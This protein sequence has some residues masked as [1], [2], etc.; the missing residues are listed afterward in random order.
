ML[1]PFVHTLRLLPTLDRQDKLVDPYPADYCYPTEVIDLPLP[2]KTCLDLPAHTAAKR[3]RSLTSLL[4]QRNPHLLADTLRFSKELMKGQ[5]HLPQDSE[6]RAPRQLLSTQRMR[7]RN[8]IRRPKGI[9]SGS[10]AKKGGSAQGQ[11]G[12]CF[13]PPM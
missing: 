13:W 1:F 6:R 7:E 5:D 2:W 4:L 3:Y 8:W 12:V 10:S 9:M 11:K